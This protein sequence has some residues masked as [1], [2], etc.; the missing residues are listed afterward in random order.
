MSAILITGANRGIGLAFAGRAAADGWRV[1]ATCRDPAKADALNALAGDVSVHRLDVADPGAIAAL[2]AALA[3]QALDI[4]L[5]N[6]GIYGLQARSFGA[7]DPDAWIETLRVNTLA[8]VLMTERF[9]DH[10]AQGRRRLVVNI[11][12][13]MG[14]TDE[15]PG[16]YYAYRSS[17]AA[18][19][20]ATANLAVD[21][22][23][24]GIAV[25]VFHPGWVRT[26]MGGS[27][28]PLDPDQAVAEMWRVIGGLSLA[29][30]G[31]F[32]DHDGSVIPW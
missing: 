2:G 21:L 9:I 18:L 29:D 23:G 27:A 32:F 31:A 11:S 26:A 25:V 12:S 20:N 5:N 15:A 3:G 14:S 6:A 17:K 19:N 16:D 10:L 22:A 24:R 4:L 7:L 8:P 1:I 13:R 30:S 28:A